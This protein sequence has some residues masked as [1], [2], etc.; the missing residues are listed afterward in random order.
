ML[1]LSTFS[2][3]DF[4]SPGGFNQVFQS[5]EATRQG[6]AGRVGIVMFPILLYFFDAFSQVIPLHQH[7]P[8]LAGH[9][10]HGRLEMF[11]LFFP[12]MMFLVVGPG[13]VAPKRF[14]Y[15]VFPEITF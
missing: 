10:I 14:V 4:G 2:L 13:S 9:G 5:F 6:G 11:F 12:D 15:M 1:N 3:S 8:A 7:F